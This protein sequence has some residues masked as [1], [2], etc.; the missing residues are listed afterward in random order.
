MYSWPI[1][2]KPTQLYFHWPLGF[3]LLCLAFLTYCYFAWLFWFSFLY[4]HFC[5]L[6]LVSR[7]LACLFLGKDGKKKNIRSIEYGE[8]GG[9]LGERENV[10][11]TLDENFSPKVYKNNKKQSLLHVNE[12]KWI[13][14]KSKTRLLIISWKFSTVGVL[15]PYLS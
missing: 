6:L 12:V 9:R 10:E 14:Y 7:L 1:E 3:I 4:L 8:H 5:F 2:K 13:F 15:F 11:Y